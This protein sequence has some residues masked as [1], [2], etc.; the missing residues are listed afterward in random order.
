MQ[1]AENNSK[2]EYEFLPGAMLDTLYQDQKKILNMWG[3][4]LPP[5]TELFENECPLWM[6]VRFFDWIIRE[7]LEA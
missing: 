5:E 3:V 7:G 2:S 1:V 6:K 4:T